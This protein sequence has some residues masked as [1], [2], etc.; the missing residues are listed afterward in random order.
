MAEGYVHTVHAEG[1][2]QTAI[3]GDLMPLPGSFLTEA[4][5]VQAG[6]DEARRRQTEHVIHNEDGSISERNSYVPDP[7]N[8]RG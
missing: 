6:R 2:W 5:A 8:R 4:E 1:R 7:S 3:E